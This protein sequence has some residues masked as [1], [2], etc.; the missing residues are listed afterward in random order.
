MPE[1]VHDAAETA[2]PPIVI[3]LAIP[4]PPLRTSPPVLADVDCVVFVR[5]TI[6]DA[7]MV[8]APEIAPERVSDVRVPTDVILP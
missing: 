7:P 8:V 5:V 4:K 1:V 3:F 6:P 2:V